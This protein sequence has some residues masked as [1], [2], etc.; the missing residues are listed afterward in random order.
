MAA[1]GQQVCAVTAVE[2]GA[3]VA[4]LAVSKAFLQWC[5]A[6][7]AMNS[8]DSHAPTTC[9]CDDVFLLSCAVMIRHRGS[10]YE[11]PVNIDS[12]KAQHATFREVRYAG[13][14]ACHA[15]SPYGQHYHNQ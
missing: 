8:S 12:A 4:V 1:V 13:A 9:T 10:L 14:A 6:C 3:D 7:Q 11:R 5:T 15:C 2:V